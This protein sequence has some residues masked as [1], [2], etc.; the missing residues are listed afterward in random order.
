M[1]LDPLVH[2]ALLPSAGMGHLTPFLRL[3]ATLLHQNC[4]VTL[5][6]P[7]PSVSKAESELISRFLSAFP[8]VNQLKFHLLPFDG[9]ISVNDPFFIQ[10]A[11]VRS[12]SHLLPPLLASVSPP[13]SAFIYD[14]TL[15]TPLLPIVH[16]LAVPHYILFTSS[17]AMFS[18][19][20]YFPTVASSGVDDAVEIPGVLTLP[21]TLI[22]HFLLIPDHPFAKIF[23]EDGPKVTKT[24][25]VFI[26]SFEGVEAQ[27]LEALNGG[28]VV[29]NLPP[30]HAVGP[31]VPFEFEKLAQR[32]A[33]IYSWLDDQPSGSVVYVSFGSRIAVGREQMREIGDGLVRSGCRFLWVVKDKK[34]DREEEEGLEAVLGLEL[35]ERMKEKGLV[36]KEWVEQG[37]ILEHKAVRWFV[38]HCGWNSVIEAAWYGV[39]IMGWPQIGDQKVNAEV[40]SKGGW[41]MWKRE[42]GWE[43]ER[44][45][46]GEEVGEAIKE[47]MSDESLVIKAEQVKEAAR[48]A[49]SVGGGC[50]VTLRTLTQ[51]WKKN[52]KN[53]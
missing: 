40:V 39:P 36:V 16:T 29:K 23:M 30:V 22:P 28:K 52:G 12:S 24:H 37:K 21:R 51:E 35:V 43:G 50:L 53:I 31:F 42:W 13:L 48:K 2:V 45:V 44:L 6:T 49:I 3:G 26:N 5:I 25:G 1:S 4:H 15:I 38:S 17:A 32:E 33:P 46:K 20:S 34:V 47:L 41:G 9:D 8:Q 10:F 11:T 7:Q 14:M 18:L 19:F 27:S